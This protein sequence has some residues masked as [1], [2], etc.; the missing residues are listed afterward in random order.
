MPTIIETR[1]LIID[2]VGFGDS[3]TATDAVVRA[4]SEGVVSSATMAAWAPAAKHAAAAAKSQHL[5]VGLC[6]EPGTLP[7]DASV[8]QLHHEVVRQLERF[9]KLL[10]EGPTHLH[11]APPWFNAATAF[12]ALCRAALHERLPVRSI[13]ANSRA[14]LKRRGIATNDG[15][16]VQPETWSREAFALALEGLPKRGVLELS[17]RADA[18]QAPAE[19][20]TFLSPSSMAALERQGLQPTSWRLFQS[21]ER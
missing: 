14:A 12:E 5:A 10:G 6:L 3:A 9:E 7:P 19:L 1:S 2:A 8:E 16:A 11:V 13:D 17:W 18:A 21:L 20:A 15:L 4:M